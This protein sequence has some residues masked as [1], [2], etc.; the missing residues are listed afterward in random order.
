MTNVKMNPIG[1]RRR[2]FTLIELLVVIA[3]IGILA[4]LLLPAL[5][6]AK[7]AAN[8]TACTNNLKQIGLALK[9]YEDREGQFPGS[10][11]PRFLSVLYGTRDQPSLKIF[12]DKVSSTIASV[13][14]ATGFPTG[15]TIDYCGRHKT[16]SGNLDDANPASCAVACDYQIGIISGLYHGGGTARIILYQDAHAGSIGPSSVGNANSGAGTEKDLTLLTTLSA[17]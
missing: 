9:I 15:E 4:G 13:S 1:S 6:K 12:K 5:Q 3:I 8:R 11:G 10:G 16:Y 17:N 2:A 7:D 14:P